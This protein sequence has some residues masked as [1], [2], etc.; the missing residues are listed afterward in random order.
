MSGQLPHHEEFLEFHQKNPM[1]YDQ[2]E[3]L[4]FKL[5]VR[6]VDRWGMKALWEVLRYELAIATNFQ[7]SDYKLNNNYTAS[8]ARLLMERNE[9]DLE[10]FFEIRERRREEPLDSSGPID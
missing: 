6:G 7:A 8:Y 3:R 1:V 5:K 4:A 2:L 10:G 9:I